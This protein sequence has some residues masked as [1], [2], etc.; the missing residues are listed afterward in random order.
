MGIVPK[1]EL[2]KNALMAI[3]NRCKAMLSLA[4]V[5]RMA[6]G[7]IVDEID[8]ETVDLSPEAITETAIFEIID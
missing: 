6:G 3:T 7:V 1:R 2:Y 8:D 5:I 4:D